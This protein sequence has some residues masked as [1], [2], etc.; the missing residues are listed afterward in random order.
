MARH[1]LVDVRRDAIAKLAVLAFGLTLVMAIAFMVSYHSFRFI[2]AIPPIGVQLNSRLL[3]LLFLVLLTMVAIS[4]AIVSYASLFLAR[5]T[6]FFFENPLPP[7]AIFFTKLLES[8]V[9]SGWA[10]LVLCLPVLTAFGL[11]RQA[12]G[13]YYVESLAILLLFILFCG[14]AGTGISLALLSLVRRWTVRKIVA[15]SCGLVL[16]LGWGFWRSFDFSALNGEEN[17]LALNRFTISLT[18]LQSSYFPSTWATSGLL[19]A[20]AGQHRE[21]VFNLGLLLANT[22]IFLPVLHLYAGGVYG[23]R[24]VHVATPAAA[25]RWSVSERRAGGRRRRVAVPL[26]PTAALIHKDLLTFVRDPA[27]VS[28]FVLFVLLTV[29]YVL[30]LIQIPSHLFAA[31]WRVVLYFS[32]LAAIALI[33]SSFTSRF[34]FPLISLEGRA[35]WIV[36]LAPVRR[37]LLVRQKASFGRLLILSLGILAGLC[38]GLS[39]G[40]ELDA[41]ASVVYTVALAGWI[42]TAL[43]IGFGAAYPNLAEDN[44]ARIA[45]GFGGTLNFFA[46]ALAV[47]GLIA[48]EAFPYVLGGAEPTPATRV[49]AH[50]ASLAF[51]AGLSAAAMRSGERAIARMEF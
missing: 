23:R 37:T 17:L 20:A 31:R 34:L 10:T 50:L 43:A 47:I 45:V 40:L 22:L 2:E 30:S 35:F 46:S 39:L 7:V 4:N 44:P 9:F 11:V 42:L 48:I 24:W 27:Q 1:A 8:V 15:V 49:I 13:L 32:N 6:R 25:E 33:L 3:G 19:A 36:G 38:S 26:S 51:A 12:P 14:L 28:Q 29:V 16:V 41:I 5:E 18:A 21:V